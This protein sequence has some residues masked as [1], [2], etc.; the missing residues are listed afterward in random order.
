MMRKQLR[1]RGRH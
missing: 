1:T